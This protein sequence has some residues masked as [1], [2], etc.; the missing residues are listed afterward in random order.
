M[1]TSSPWLTSGTIN[2]TFARAQ[3]V[4]R[5]RIQV[6][7]VNLDYAACILK[8]Q[9]E[10]II[11]RDFDSRAC[12]RLRPMGKRLSRRPLWRAAVSPD[13]ALPKAS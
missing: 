11:R 4:Q 1:P 10:R 13:D 3:L 5:G 9:D 7:P 8:I 12:H 2:W 6:D